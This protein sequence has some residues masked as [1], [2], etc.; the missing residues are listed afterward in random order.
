MWL[1]HS[2]DTVEG[3]HN[4]VDLHQAVWRAAVEVL[5]DLRLWLLLLT[6]HFFCGTLINVAENLVSLLLAKNFLNDTDLLVH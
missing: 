6:F 2:V 1:L 3:A 4:T 5:F